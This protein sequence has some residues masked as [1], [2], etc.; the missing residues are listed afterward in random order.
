MLIEIEPNTANDSRAHNWL[1]RLL[2]R[3]EDGWHIWDVT[4]LEGYTQTSWVAER[5]SQGLWINDLYKAAVRQ[6]AWSSTLHQRYIRVTCEPCGVNELTPEQG[7]RF[8]DEK[9]VIIVENRNSDG[10]FLERIVSELDGGL[11]KWMRRSPEPTRIDSLGGKGEMEKE[12]SKYAGIYPRPRLVVVVDSDRTAPNTNPSIEAQKLEK[13]CNEHGFPCWV[14]AKRE[15]ENYLPR[16]LLEQKEN[17]GSDYFQ[18]IDSWDRLSDEQKDY[19]DMKSGLPLDSSEEVLFATLDKRD[20]SVLSNGFGNHIGDC[21]KLH[22]SR[23]GSSK[24]AIAER[25]GRDIERGLSLIKQE[26]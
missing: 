15:S 23:G 16:L 6:S 8:A 21:W 9:L 14:L 3:I 5:G 7:A 13:T 11:G 22:R 19:Y 26:V 18:K 17:V 2:H 4:G 10:D 20:R 1:D 24:A 25:G 12:V